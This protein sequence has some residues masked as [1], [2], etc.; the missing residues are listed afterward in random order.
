MGEGA[1]GSVAPFN[2]EEVS[3]LLTEMCRLRE[4]MIA[5]TSSAGS[6]LDKVNSDYRLSAENLLHYLAL[7]RHDI[8]PLQLRLAALG[9]SSLGRSE[10]CVLATVEAVIQ[11][12]EYLLGG[13]RSRDQ[14]VLSQRVD[15]LSG[16]QLLVAH[17]ERLLGPPMSHR[18]VRIMVTMPTEA[19]FDYGLVHGLMAKG[20][21]CMRINCAHD[22]PGVWAG[23]I[24]NLRRAEQA[25]GRTCQVV[26]DLGGPKLR[27][28]P[29]EPGPA[30]MHVRPHRD[31]FGKT[32]ASARIWL[33]PEESPHDA[34]SPCDAQLR[35]PGEWLRSLSPNR[36]IRLIDARGTVR[37]WSVIELANEG[38]WA[39]SA[40]TC[41]L[42]PGTKLEVH[43]VSSGNITCSIG[44]F[45]PK[46]GALILNR[47]D[48]LAV[49][50]QLIP[51]HPATFD[52]LGRTL[53][54][55][56]ISCTIPEI[57]SQVRAGET[58]WFDDGKI[59]GVIEH[60]EADR[61]L[62][63]ITHARPGGAKLRA[64]KGINLPDSRLQLDALTA[65]DLKN[66]PFVAEHADVVEMSFA[67]SARDVSLLE[68]HLE[69]LHSHKPAIV[70]KVETRHGF[71]NLPSMLLAAMRWPCCGVMIA[72]GD[73]AVECGFERLAEV[74]EEILWICEAA[75]IPVIWATQVLESL[76]QK[77]MA[78]R[79]EITDAAMG[80]RAE[81]VMLNKGPHVLAAVDVLDD[82][83]TRMQ[84][85]Q[86]KKRAMLRELRLA[87]VRAEENP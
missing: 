48:L 25:I 5:E 84:S 64:D 54:P 19:A 40:K 63:Q 83:L 58:I 34:P 22:A 43:G 67:N 71:E 76:A 74:Q 28:G 15:F 73:L 36:D 4:F 59:G 61:L 77:G 57:F 79:A 26:M 87:H 56:S 46:A 45:A 47:G 51:G 44:P 68:Q 55:A 42:T 49:N 41:Y 24:E 70:L 38:C 6:R 3:S 13:N 81:C 21:N 8:R 7:R 80:H 66:L 33:T 9:L 39:E 53:T 23:M 12:L 60:V 1:K 78:S 65:D 86:A 27:T 31:T 52:R 72:R 11:A 35:V 82:I 30:V 62:V 75:H 17:T 20:M 85:H 10:S 50:A 2:R 18:S 16:Q 14:R 69:A 29:V 37:R 32:T